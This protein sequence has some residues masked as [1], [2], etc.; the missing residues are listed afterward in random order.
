MQTLYDPDPNNDMF[1]LYERYYVNIYKYKA[2][3]DRWKFTYWWGVEESE[4]ASGFDT[5][6]RC[7]A[8][9]DLERKIG[10]LV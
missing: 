5:V 2:W 6:E 7:K 1:H 8:S 9:I 10:V 3:D 4:Y